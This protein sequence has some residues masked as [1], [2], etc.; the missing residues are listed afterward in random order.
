MQ[1]SP[2]GGTG[3]ISTLCQP[4]GRRQRVVNIWLSCS[5]ILNDLISWEKLT[6]LM[7]GQT[8]YRLQLDS[9]DYWRLP[10]NRQESTGAQRT[11]APPINEHTAYRV[12]PWQ[13][14]WTKRHRNCII[15]K[16]SSTSP[17]QYHAI[18]RSAHRQS[19]F[20]HHP[21]S[22]RQVAGSL[23]TDEVAWDTWSRS[24]SRQ[25]NSQNAE[26]LIGMTQNNHQRRH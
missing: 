6:H 18:R 9:F 26:L 12:A 13:T 22:S 19:Q 8:P 1:E 21:G 7:A 17:R 4:A 24:R 15:T 10:A 20:W 11:P 5:R 3:M 16:V 2:D 25:T 14:H 23:K